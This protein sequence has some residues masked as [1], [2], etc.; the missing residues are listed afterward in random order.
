MPERRYELGALDQF[1]LEMRRLADDLTV[2]RAILVAMMDLLPPP[3]KTPE[4][5]AA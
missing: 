1:E 4:T 2:L 5:I 3:P